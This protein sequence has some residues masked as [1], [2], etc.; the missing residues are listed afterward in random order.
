LKYGGQV[1]SDQCSLFGH[2]GFYIKPWMLKDFSEK[3]NFQ[4][5]LIALGDNKVRLNRFEEHKVEDIDF[6]K[7]LLNKFA[8]G[9]A[10]EFLQ[11]RLS[12]SK[13]KEEDV[14]DL[15]KKLL[16]G[17]MIYGPQAAEMGLID[18]VKT[19]HEVFK[20]GEIVMSKPSLKDRLFGGADKSFS[21]VDDIFENVVDNKMKNDSLS[22]EALIE[23]LVFDYTMRNSVM[24]PH[25]IL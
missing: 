21:L 4:V 10:D 25:K 3:W 1:Y 24:Y 17:D 15:K 23:D 19:P 5:K 9:I 6:Y 16:S 20:G 13:I 14:E 7:N 8:E 12:K 18:G 2:L 11:S 22:A